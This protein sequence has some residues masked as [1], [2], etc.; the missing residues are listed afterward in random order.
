[1]AKDNF[2]LP[3]LDEF[4]HANPTAGFVP[5]S[6]NY[7]QSDEEEMGLTYEQLSILGRLR[8]GSKLGPFRAW[9]RLVHE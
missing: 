5:F 7:V 1:M 3:I 4:I 9:E 8:K 2:D 6:E